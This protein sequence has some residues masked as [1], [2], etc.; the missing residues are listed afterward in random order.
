MGGRRLFRYFFLVA[1]AY[2]VTTLGAGV[3]DYL[4]RFDLSKRPT[5]SYPAELVFAALWLSA[6]LTWRSRGRRRNGRNSPTFPRTPAHP[7][8]TAAFR[9][10]LPRRPGPIATDRRA[11][12][13]ER[14]CSSPSWCCSHSSSAGGT[15]HDG[16]YLGGRQALGHRHAALA[17]QDQGSRRRKA[18]ESDVEHRRSANC[19]RSECAC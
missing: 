7:R 12:A 18:R 1:L 13:V 16:C 11:G 17:E 2:G 6:R 4:T 5:C 3:A 14:A 15:S 10:L 8:R 19:H 9:R